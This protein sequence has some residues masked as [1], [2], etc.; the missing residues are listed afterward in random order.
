MN[1]KF[2][3]ILMVIMSIFIVGGVYGVDGDGDGYLDI[4]NCSDLQNINLNLT[5]NYEL[6]NNIDCSDTINWNAGEGFQPI[7]NDTN[8]FTGSLD[9][10]NFA[11][12]DL[13]IDLS[14]EDNVGLF[15]Y[16]DGASIINLGIINLNISGNDYVGG[17][18]GYAIEV[19]IDDCYTTGF[20]D[21]IW[22]DVGGLVGNIDLG[23]INNSYSSASVTGDTLV[24]GLIGM[25]WDS[26]IVVQNSYATGD[27]TGASFVGGLVGEAYGDILNCTANGT[28]IGVEFVGGL[29]GALDDNLFDSYATGAVTGA[30]QSTGGLVG[31][32]YS[33]GNINNSY[34]TGDVVSTGTY[35]G[36]L[37]GYGSG[38][39]RNSYSIGNVTASDDYI[40]GGLV[41]ETDNTVIENCY[42]TGDVT[43]KGYV[44]GLIADFDG[45]INNSYA[46]GDVV[47]TEDRVGGFIGSCYSGPVYNS[48]ALGNVSAGDD[49]TNSDV[50]GFAGYMYDEC[51]IYNSFSTGDVTGTGNRVGGFA[52][53]MNSILTNVYWYNRSQ[54][55]DCYS[56]GN[57][58]CTAIDTE[59]YFFDYDN[60][61]MLLTAGTGWDFVNIWDDV[62]NG[63]N[64]PS[65]YFGIVE[66]EPEPNNEPNVTS[67]R[68]E[69][70]GFL[71]SNENTTG[72]CTGY[73]EDGDNLTINYIWYVNGTSVNSGTKSGTY[74]SGVEV[75][76]NSLNS[77]YYV[78]G[79]NITFSCQ[80]DDSELQSD[81]LN[82][83][84]HLI[85][86]YYNFQ[87]T[88]TYVSI[89]PSNHEVWEVYDVYVGSSPN[90]YFNATDINGDN[91]Q[92]Q[93]RVIK[94]GVYS[95]ITTTDW[96][97]SGV[98]VNPGAISGPFEYGTQMWI[99]SRAYDNNSY[100]SWMSSDVYTILNS[101]PSMLVATAHTTSTVRENQ[102][103]SGVC[104][105]TD[106][107]VESYITDQVLSYT[108]DWYSGGSLVYTSSSG[109]LPYTYT[110]AGNSIILECTAY[111]GI[112]YSEPLNSSA[113]TITDTSN[114]PT[115]NLIDISGDYTFINGTCQIDDLDGDLIDYGFKFYKNGILV[116]E[117]TLNDTLSGVEQDV[118]YYD[119][120]SSGQ[121]WTFSCSGTDDDGSINW[122]NTT[123]SIP[124][125]NFNY[126]Y[127]SD[128]DTIYLEFDTNAEI[129]K[130]Y[131]DGVFR[132]NV[133]S[134]GTT[135][136]RLNSNT[137]YNVTLIPELDGYSLNPT[138]F[139]AFT[140]ETDNTPP[141]T[142][143][144]LYP[145]NAYTDST[146]TG[147][148]VS[149]DNDD[150]KVYYFYEFLVNGI[151]VKSG[152]TNLVD[153]AYLNTAT[154]SSSYFDFND[155]IIFNV[156][157]YDDEGSS[158]YESETLT[159]L[160][161]PPTFSDKFI[162]L[163][164][165]NFIP[166]Y[167]YS[168]LDDDE[169]LSNKTYKW[170]KNDV[171]IS[172]NYQYPNTNVNVNDVLVCEITTGDEYN[173]VT[174]NTSSYMVGDFEAPVVSSFSLPTT[175]YTDNPTLVSVVCSDNVG[176][177]TYPLVTTR[178]PSYTIEEFYLSD[179]EL[180][181]YSGYHTFSIPGTYTNI[182]VECVDGNGNRAI[183]VPDNYITALIDYD[184]GSGGLDEEEEDEE[185][186]EISD[187]FILKPETDKIY[188]SPGS[189]KRV[190]FE[191]IS[192]VN[193]DLQFTT[194]VSS[195]YNGY[196]FISFES[197]LK[198]F[199]FE[200]ENLGG[201]SSDNKYVRYYIDVPEDIL[202]DEI[203]KTF[204]GVIEINGNGV[205]KY[206]EVEI[207]VSESYI[208]IWAWLNY[209]LFEIPFTKKVISDA[210]LGEDLYKGIP[211][212]VLH[213][214][215]LI[216]LIGLITAVYKNVKR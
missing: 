43:G 216:S 45:S 160:N 103:L 59:S 34:A 191:V 138:S 95:N 142:R 40:V 76:V 52:G 97:S 155:T 9:G 124:E 190:E 162:T 205:S 56:G 182:E 144:R 29:L 178:T 109:F 13:F 202:G 108:Y 184:T 62:Y 79:D 41:G 47:S 102:N 66:S 4:T 20:V 113:V 31:Q 122:T 158:D 177:S 121:N 204:E 94:D 185:Y 57:E 201:L 143:V 78:S 180:D 75:E 24:G 49:G 74:T 120:I 105:A 183:G 51:F 33:T 193:E 147:E 12:S 133:I 172:T 82:S 196:E 163:S 141:V 140:Q 107:D 90:V 92:Y 203:E 96:Y 39:I 145:R 44:G 27:V 181:E 126:S 22:G 161:S 23:S 38:T 99:E 8:M 150:I 104:G 153:Y 179:A 187:I 65:L 118:Y 167:V 55:L 116:N 58:N 80:V 169:E 28:I 173:N 84:T 7:G 67:S 69:V 213:L 130:V 200:I 83:S 73:D 159:I 101:L 1:N 46:T 166:S 195:E 165:S 86:N 106:S 129:I 18:V 14:S 2:I 211:F 36:G 15:G 16:V 123:L 139:Y 206:Y 64:Y 71:F 88:M 198:S 35:V 70:D 98:E 194:A 19:D 189:R 197:G 154:L 156:T 85:Y 93:Y 134:T 68:I 10:N 89:E 6:V 207:V 25:T 50:G 53:Y 170:Y 210:E 30:G 60:E 61:P 115:L 168:D 17:L 119:T 100:S 135:I 114:L 146:L 148:F 77:S 164:G 117:S 26:S 112:D 132:G 212:T 32:S 214:L 151:S 175:T 149:F 171:L 215:I 111:D 21:S 188:T 37:V 54:S 209:E 48:Y 5:A 42:A 136:N 81:Y 137:R 174:F 110:H 125:I 192:K 208:D 127:T 199:S 87:P 11:I 186:G 176:L 63:A 72:Y 3:L 152:I 131:L 128:M 91:I 157:V